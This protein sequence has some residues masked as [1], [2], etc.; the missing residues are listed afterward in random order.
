M[1]QT[2][3][4]DEPFPRPV[5]KLALPA[6]RALVAVAVIATVDVAASLGQA[7]H[8]GWV[9]AGVGVPLGLAAA[10]AVRRVPAALIHPGATSR[11]LA[12]ARPGVLLPAT[13]ALF[14][15]ALAPLLTTRFPPFDDY[16]NHLA[17]MH[18]IAIGDAP[19]PLH[20]FYAIHWKLIPNLAMDIVVPPL[21]RAI[22]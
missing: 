20:A 6:F 22:G 7:R 9:A 3:L 21:A 2:T 16:L 19:S 5:P 10:L 1:S 8:A 14:L 18:I 15:I 12:P 11:P 17:R 13:A 4:T